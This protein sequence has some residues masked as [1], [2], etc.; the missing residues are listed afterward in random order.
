MRTSIY[1][2]TKVGPLAHLRGAKAA[3]NQ[4]TLHCKYVDCN[5]LYSTCVSDSDYSRPQVLMLDPSTALG[6]QSIQ[7]N[8]SSGLKPAP[9]LAS[10]P[11]VRSWLKMENLVIHN[12]WNC[13]QVEFISLLAICSQRRALL[14]TAMP[15]LPSL[16]SACCCP[17]PQAA[18]PHLPSPA[19]QQ[20]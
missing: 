11:I 7:Y 1:L 6:P 3:F 20:L 8:T 18:P 15:S 14:P 9:A 5:P 16:S 10:E 12:P 2:F 13:S 4:D 19:P 17:G